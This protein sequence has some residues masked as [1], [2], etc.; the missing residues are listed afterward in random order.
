MG[1]EVWLGGGSVGVWVDD[2]QEKDGVERNIRSLIC[3][4]VHYIKLVPSAVMVRE[5]LFC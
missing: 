3:G 4:F 1:T 5:Y 2:E